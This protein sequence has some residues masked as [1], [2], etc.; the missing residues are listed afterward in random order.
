MFPE[1]GR[2]AIGAGRQTSITP[3][4]AAGRILFRALLAKNDIPEDQV[5]L[6]II[7]SDMNPLKAGQVDA[8]TGWKTN[9]KAPDTL[10]DQR[11]DMAVRPRHGK[12]R[13]RCRRQVSAKR[14]RRLPANALPRHQGCGRAM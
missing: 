2:L 9:I 1:T 10:G 11:V 12:A 5:E 7:G 13:L 3:S 8:I 14:R 6:A 4:R